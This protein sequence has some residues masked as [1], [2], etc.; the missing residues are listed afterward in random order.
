MNRNLIFSIVILVFAGLSHNPMA[1]PTDRYEELTGDADDFEVIEKPWREAGS[2][3]AEFPAPEAWKKL[4]MDNAPAGFTLFLDVPGMTVN[5]QDYVTRYW[6]K[7][8]SASGSESATYEAVRCST[9]EYLVY[10][11]GYENRDPRVTAV[12]LPR[13]Q[14][15]GQRQEGNYREELARYYL[16]AGVSPK[17][18][19]QVHQ[20]LRGTYELNNPFDE[21]VDL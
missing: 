16:C 5:E 21:D 15:L 12:K 13:W 18:L 14:K 17:T 19:K 11:Y 4:R 7:L 10:A 2:E 6:I 8:K 9:G 1:A 3:V 20:Y